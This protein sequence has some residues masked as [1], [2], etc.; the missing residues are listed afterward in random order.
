MAFT[1]KSGKLRIEVTD[2][3]GILTRI[4]GAALRVEMENSN[5]HVTENAGS[6]EEKLTVFISPAVFIVESL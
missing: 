5:V 1:A 4:S 6:P 3:T 2:S